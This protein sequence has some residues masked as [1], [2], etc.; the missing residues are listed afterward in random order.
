MRHMTNTN[1]NTNTSKQAVR[2]GTV[3]YFIFMCYT[4]VL[5]QHRLWISI[6]LLCF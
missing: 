2:N 1:E 4:Y 6:R 3:T 5:W